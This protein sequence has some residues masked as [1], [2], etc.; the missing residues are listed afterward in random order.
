M[1]INFIVDTTARWGDIESLEPADIARQPRRFVGGRNSWIAQ[2]FVRLRPAL[3]ARGWKVTASPRFIPGSISVAHRDDVNRF[4]TDAHASFLV[5][6]RADRAPV[7]ACDFAVA[8]N[9]LQLQSHERFVPLWPQPGLIARD[10]LRG[11]RIERMAY[12]G[13]NSSTPRWFLDHEFLGGLSRRGIR[14]EVRERA[15][16][17][18][19]DVDVVLAARS[20]A[21]HLL[22]TKPATK[23]YNG[24]LSRVPVLA[25]PEPAYRELRRGPLDFIEVD[26][27][28]AVLRALDRLR[29]APELYEAMVGNGVARGAEFN[30]DAT[31][32][33]WI[34]LLEGEIVPAY[35]RA[36]PGLASRRSW[37]LWAMARQKIASRVFRAK[38]AGERSASGM[39]GT[40]GRWR[41]EDRSIA[42]PAPWV[43]VNAECP[44]R[45]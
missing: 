6:V 5:V 8:Q 36:R 43:G 44:A 14:F 12:L 41:R 17:N 32:A 13:R 20:D 21:A 37:F 22:A 1:H 3:L 34:S 35:Q 23:V 27:P 29:G 26:A 19:R 42:V 4:A 9:R 15:W 11:V 31:T 45:D 33:R 28:Q 38:V 25:S 7:A 18:C 2:S 24:W 10:A 30:V 16:E 39:P 40:K